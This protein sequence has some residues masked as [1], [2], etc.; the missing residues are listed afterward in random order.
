M[1]KRPVQL[2]WFKRDLRVTDHA[3]LASA[4]ARGPV[5]PLYIIEPDFWAEPDA[6]ARHW[7]FL[8]QSLG[9]LREALARL[10][11]PLVILRGDAVAVLEEIATAHPTAALWSH[12][13]TGNDWTYARD[14]KGGSMVQIEIHPMA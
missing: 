9:E 14:K 2:V 10:G 6:S 13:E 5:L 7:T 11:Q 8:R 12:Q 1:E 3:C 4:A